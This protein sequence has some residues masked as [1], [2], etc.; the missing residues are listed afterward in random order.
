MEGGQR[1]KCNGDWFYP[2]G[3]KAVQERKGPLPTFWL[4]QA[5][6]ADSGCYHHDGTAG[7]QSGSMVREHKR[8]KNQKISTLSWVY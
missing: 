8:A 3:D 6:N 2:L 4:P 5:P 1:E 7:D